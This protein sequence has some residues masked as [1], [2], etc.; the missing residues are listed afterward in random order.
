MLPS[1][2]GRTAIKSGRQVVPGRLLH[3]LSLVLGFVK[4]ACC[5]SPP[6]CVLTMW[7]EPQVFGLEWSPSQDDTKTWVPSRVAEAARGDALLA[8]GIAV[9]VPPFTSKIKTAGKFF[10]AKNDL[11]PYPGYFGED[12]GKV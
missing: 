6:D 8:S 1:Y 10:S 11:Q 9:V 3:M 2:C 12:G 7:T 5:R 4:T